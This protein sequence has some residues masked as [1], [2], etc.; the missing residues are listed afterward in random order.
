RSTELQNDQNELPMSI[1]LQEHAAQQLKQST[2]VDFV[3]RLGQTLAEALAFAHQ[4]NLL[5]LD[6]K[7]SNILIT[8]DGQPILLDLDVARQPIAA[9][10]SSVPW[11]GGTP[12]YMS[13]EQRQAMQ[14]LALHQ[15]VVTPI[16]E[17][18]DI[19]SLG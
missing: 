8:P 14:T 7:P 2:W 18:S 4:R 10:T 11:F 9:G 19:Y 5:H 6:V 16:D 12:G 13:P 17:R 1:P 15:P 3:L